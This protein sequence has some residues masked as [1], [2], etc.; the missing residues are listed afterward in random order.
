[1]KKK[2]LIIFMP[3][4]EGGGVEKNL[5]IISNYLVNKIYDI[6]L[7]TV[8]KSAKLRFNKK[9]K[10]ISPKNYFW[11][12]LNKKIKYI[13]CLYLLFTKLLFNRNVVIFCFQANVYCTLLCKIFGVRIVI[14]SNSSPSGWSKN[15]IK[16]MIFKKLLGL[17]DTII[18]NSIDFKNELKKKLNLNSVCIYNP[19]NKDEVVFQSKKN[20]KIIFKKKNVLRIINVARF[21]DQKDH[22]TLLKAANILKEK[23][24]FELSI[25]GR[26]INKK[27]MENYILKNGLKNFVKI[28]KFTD[29]PYPL[30]KQADLFVLTSKFEGLPNVLLES[31]TLK[32]F[33]ISSNCPTG[34]REILDNGTNG[35]LFK[36]GDYKDLSKKIIYYN[37]NKVKLKKMI[38]RGYKRLDRFDFKNNLQKYFLILGKFL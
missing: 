20:K 30:I 13:V 27:I 29:N 7:I 22:I 24:R 4:I 31:Q 34:P 8:T 2:K 3:S 16:K 15:F 32:K 33:V 5:Y 14:R 19:L 21:T 28:I 36:I 18:V 17:A 38:N 1:M 6:S 37:S 12:N 35:L 11:E 9:I 26:G 25:V 10:F 23:I